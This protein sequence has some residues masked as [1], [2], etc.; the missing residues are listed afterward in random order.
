VSPRSLLLTVALLLGLSAPAQAADLADRYRPVLQWGDRA[1]ATETED[2]TIEE[3]RELQRKLKV[4]RTMMD[5]HQAFSFVAA[6]S[7]I[8]TEVVG[9]INDIALDTGSP[10][11]SGLEPGL[12]THRILAGVSLTSYLGAGLTA[13]AA[14][15]ALRL[16]G[17]ATT[18]GQVDSGKLHVVFSV[19]HGIAMATVMTTGFLQ[20]NIIPVK[21]GAWD[22]IIVAH[23][24][25][26]FTAA[27][28]V[29]AAGITIATL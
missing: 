1:D 15:R 10:A 2:L 11:R 3:R 29:L 16:N 26:G 17:G 23:K 6:G 27:G 19:I 7:I 25:S 20:S 4:R 24:I 28:F 21:D 22:A 8:A 18:P 12:M 13:W 5:L 9:L 14:P